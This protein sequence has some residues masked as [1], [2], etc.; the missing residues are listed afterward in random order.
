MDD[1]IKRQMKPTNKNQTKKAIKRTSKTSNTAVSNF[2]KPSTHFSGPSYPN[3]T[4]NP[5]LNQVNP[6]YYDNHSKLDMMPTA[7]TWN[8]GRKPS[9]RARKMNPHSKADN[10]GY[11][12]SNTP[13]LVAAPYPNNYATGATATHWPSS[14]ERNPSL[15]SSNPYNSSLYPN[16]NTPSN[17]FGSYSNGGATCL[18]NFSNLSSLSHPNNSN[19][20]STNSFGTPNETD[21]SPFPRKIAF[22][23]NHHSSTSPANHFMHYT[24]SNAASHCSSKM[25]SLYPPNHNMH[26]TNPFCLPQ[27]PPIDTSI[28][29][30]PLFPSSLLYPNPII[31]TD[32]MK[33]YPQSDSSLPANLFMSPSSTPHGNTRPKY[34]N[35][36][37]PKRDHE[38]AFQQSLLESFSSAGPYSL[39]ETY[40]FQQC[41]GR[42]GKSNYTNRY[43]N[44]ATS[45]NSVPNCIT[46]INGGGT[47]QSNRSDGDRKDCNNNS[48]NN[49][50]KKNNQQ[51]QSTVFVK[52]EDAT[53]HPDV[54]MDTRARDSSEQ[55]VLTQML[56]MGFTDIREILSSVRRLTDLQY[57]VVPSSDVV[58]CD[59]IQ[60]REEVDE[61]KKMDAARLL[62][63]QSRK[64]ESKRL[65]LAAD[66]EF[67]EK[68]ISSSIKEWLT[69]EKMFSKS[70]IL[71]GHAWESLEKVFD[72]DILESPM[73]PSS[74]SSSELLSDNITILKSSLVELLKLEKKSQVWY[75]CF[76]P[77]YYFE[78][79]VTNRLMGC[80]DNST[81]LSETTNNNKKKAKKRSPIKKPQKGKQKVQTINIQ[82]QSHDQE[83]ILSLQFLIQDE[84]KQLNR[85]MFQLSE[86]FSGVPRIFQQ[87][88][89]EYK[90]NNVTDCQDGAE[91]D[92][93]DDYIEVLS[94]NPNVASVPSTPSKHDRT[95][96]NRRPVTR[97]MTS[98][99][100]NPNDMN[101]NTN[102]IELL[103]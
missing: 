75:G 84:I 12:M 26:Q 87:V 76:L 67:E 6:C 92:D 83:T 56:D 8:Q 73:S 15:P 86:Q 25:S 21:S 23:P 68:L 33:S 89:D 66:Q 80:S 59:L 53:Y 77:R 90:K 38:T 42:G 11:S 50:S 44:N 100:K 103:D 98:T 39:P 49:G 51:D 70:W 45:N 60:Q 81:T 71:N 18:P 24:N 46:T 52:L 95:M 72:K 54:D 13:N 63:E 2:P 7:P 58:M 99:T 40:R 19:T 29:N 41:S 36:S 94:I 91:N 3:S 34:S 78:I 37:H 101:T 1:A 62:S 74:S 69:N 10:F 9:T 17:S 65:R 64:E 32:S 28:P 93:D 22:H 96:R 88:Y 82:Q 55:S 97:H 48:N 57:G 102:P 30:N 4:T 31:P 35:Q 47:P 85:V 43:N 14:S 16:H 61:A 27:Q 5:Y 20:Y 79:D